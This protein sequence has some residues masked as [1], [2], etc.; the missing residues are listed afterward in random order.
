MEK[1]WTILIE[2]LKIKKHIFHNYLTK[3][4][5]KIGCEET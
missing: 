3:F 5:N 1:T 4:F 2:S